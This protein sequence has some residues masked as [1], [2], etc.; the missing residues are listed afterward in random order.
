M[1]S[2]RDLIQ[3]LARLDETTYQSALHA[4]G[5]L[6]HPELEAKLV[7]KKR[8]SEAGEQLYPILLTEG[9]VKMLMELC[10]REAVRLTQD[11]RNAP[12]N[13]SDGEMNGIQSDASEVSYLAGL[14]NDEYQKIAGP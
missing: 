12:A 10:D 1:L 14:L 13:I 6:R 9:Q 3:E 5:H 4:Y 2:R 7:E 11:I 8:R